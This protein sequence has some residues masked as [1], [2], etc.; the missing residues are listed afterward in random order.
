MGGAIG[1]PMLFT[2]LCLVVA[3]VYTI[4]KKQRKPNRWNQAITSTQTTDI[5]MAKLSSDVVKG[6]EEISL[7]EFPYMYENDNIY[8]TIQDE[9]KI[10]GA[11]EDEY[12]EMNP[13]NI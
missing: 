2:I 1:T 11:N 7:S 9:D 5:H 3:L 8:S 6:R 4:K 13:T 12:I 10:T